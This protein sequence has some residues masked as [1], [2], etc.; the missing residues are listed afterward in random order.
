MR[1]C[2]PIVLRKFGLITFVF[3][4][5]LEKNTHTLFYH[6]FREASVHC[7]RGR[8][9]ETSFPEMEGGVRFL[10]VVEAKQRD[11][12]VVRH[13]FMSAQVAVEKMLQETGQGLLLQ[14]IG[15]EPSGFLAFTFG[16]PSVT[17]RV[18]LCLPSRHV[19]SRHILSEGIP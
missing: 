8:T 4:A 5:V 7:L 9:S 11:R 19:C 10:R 18:R 6:L 13:V 17:L 2:G 14:H 12:G 3:W 1:L 16:R 15:R